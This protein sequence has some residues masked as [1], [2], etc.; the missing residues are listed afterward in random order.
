MGNRGC[1]HR[2]T[3]IVRP[4]QVRRWIICATEFRGRHY[5]QWRPGRWTALFF[6]DEAVAMAAGH[7]PCAECRREAY[8][9]YR[10]AWLAAFGAWGGVDET[11]RRLHA[12]R[13]DGR[14]QQRHHSRQWGE[15]PDGAFVVH[16][17]IPALVW[18]AEIRPWTV[19]GY[20]AAVARPV[21]GDATVITPA[22]TVEV[23][24]YGYRPDV[25]D[26]ARAPSCNR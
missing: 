16:G 4:W 14:R 12:D 15:L 10:D 21:T 23:L 20:G 8:N 19:D 2:G 3:D 7:R 5:V 18:Q 9:R 6:H 22:A 17:G 1:I 25:A 24:Q 13:V 26:A 11:D